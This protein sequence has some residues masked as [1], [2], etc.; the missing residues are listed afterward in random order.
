LITSI[1]VPSISVEE[2]RSVEIDHHK[3]AAE[4][5]QHQSEPLERAGVSK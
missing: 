2:V 5:M 3:A 1:A 4:W